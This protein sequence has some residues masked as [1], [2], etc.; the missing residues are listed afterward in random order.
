MG[1]LPGSAGLKPPLSQ[2]LKGLE[3]SLFPLSPAP[4][5]PPDHRPRR[6][7]IKRGG[8]RHQNHQ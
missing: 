7:R 5:P 6:G 4:L 2:R 1:T 8:R 3:K